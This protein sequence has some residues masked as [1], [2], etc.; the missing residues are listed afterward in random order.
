[1]RQQKRHSADIVLTGQNLDLDVGEFLGYGRCDIPNSVEV[2]S[3]AGSQV[4]GEVYSPADVHCDD[5][6]LLD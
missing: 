5:I 1:M 2:P 3:L 6:A 4:S